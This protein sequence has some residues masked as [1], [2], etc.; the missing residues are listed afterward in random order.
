M[1]HRLLLLSTNHRLLLLSILLVLDTSSRAA[2]PLKEEGDFRE[3]E[4]V[5]LT[6]LDATLHLEIRYATTNNFVGRAVYP[7]ARAFLQRPAAEALLRAHESLK[8]K[9]YG[10]VVFDAYRPLSVVKIFWL[11][12][13]PEHKKFVANPELGSTHSRGCAVDVTLMDLKTGKPV[14]MP[15]EYDEWSERSHSE[16]SGGDR[17]SRRLRKLLRTAMEAEGY[18]RCA[19][20]WWHF[21][22]K[23]WEE[24]RNMDIPFSKIKTL[25]KEQ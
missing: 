2:N 25:S 12:T 18:L 8:K 3:P 6:T 17:E 10:L 24:Y 4:L 21:T 15:S 7:E 11:E 13:A 22:Y 23:D 14:T 16:Y 1:N 5:E 19:H 9:G 20:E